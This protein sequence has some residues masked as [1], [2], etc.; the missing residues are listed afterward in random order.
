[1][2]H[3]TCLSQTILAENDE[4]NYRIGFYVLNDEDEE[5][6]SWQPDLT[7]LLN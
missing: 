7:E 3:E 5:I 2:E 4:I 6:E 1:M